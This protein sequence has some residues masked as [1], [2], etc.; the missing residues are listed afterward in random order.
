MAR[1]PLRESPL[2]LDVCGGVEFNVGAGD[3]AA[4]DFEFATCFCTFENFGR[5]AGEGCDALGV[6][7]GL[8]C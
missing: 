5:G 1:R 7:A 2:L 4:E 8:G 3:V 6:G